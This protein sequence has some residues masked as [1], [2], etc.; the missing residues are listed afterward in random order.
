MFK[1]EDG[2]LKIRKV[3]LP[4]IKTNVMSDLQQSYRTYI[5]KTIFDDMEYIRDELRTY[6]GMET[7]DLKVRLGSLVSY[8]YNKSQTYQGKFYYPVIGTFSLKGHEVGRDM[9]LLRI[10]FMDDY[11]KINVDGASRVV[12]MVQRAAEDISYDMK[13]GLFNIA[14]PYANVRIVANHNSVKM[15]YG[16]NSYNITD[17]ITYM[18]YEA[19][20]NTKLYDVFRNTYLINAF[21]LN[22]HAINKYVHD[23]FF[24]QNP[25]ISKFRSVQYKL[26]NT[27]EALNN[28]LSIDRAA[29]CVL[30]R[31]VLDYPEGTTV[32]QSMIVE[33]KRARIN[34]IYVQARELL[35][36][37]RLTQS[38]WFNEIPAGTQNC[39]LLRRKLPQFAD[40]T[41]IPEDVT[42][43][44]QNMIVLDENSPL[45][46]EEAE[47]LLTIGYKSVLV[48]PGK[49]QSVLT[50][51]FEREIVGNYT[52]RLGELTDDIPEGRSADEWVYYYNNPTLAPIENDYLTAHDLIA[53]T[54]VMGEIH[55]TGRTQLLNRDNSF[56]KKVM[57]INEVFSES[58]RRAGKT[59]VKRYHSNI[60]AGIQSTVS[61]KAFYGLT[62]DWI[63][64]MNKERFLAPA[65]TV[66]VS[67]EVSQVNHVVTLTESS[68]EILD[69]QRHLAMPFFGRICPYETPAGKKLGIVNTKAL[70]AIVKNGLICTPYRKIIKT[71]NGI[72]ISKN[73]VYL[74][75]KDELGHKFGDAMAFKYDDN[76]NILNTYILARIPNPDIS[77]EPFIFSTIKA[78]DLADGYVPAY[79]EQFLSP[80]AA[81]IPFAGSDDP[82]RISFGLSQI[83][84]AIYLANSQRLRVRTPM[85]KDILSYSD[86][87]RFISPCDGIVK[88]VNNMHV[89]IQRFDGSMQ[90]VLM[91]GSG[92]FGNTDVTV[93]VMVSEGQKVK[94]GDLLAEAYKY[95]QAFVVRAPYSGTVI[96]IS[97]NSIEIAK[98]QPDSVVIDLSKVDRVQINNGRIMGQS[99]IFLNIKVSVGDHVEKGQILADTCMSRDGYYSPA[100]SPLVGYISIGYNY[101]DGVCASERAAVDYTSIIA[102]TIDKKVSKKHYKSPKTNTLQGFK[103][104]AKG[105]SVGKVTLKQDSNDTTKYEVAVRATEKANGI[106]Y[107]VRTIEDTPNAR[108]YRYHLLGFNKLQVGDKMAGM[109]GDKG[110][111]SKV[112]KNSM[113]PQLRNGKVMDFIIS[114]CG[115]PSRMNLGK[116]WHTH[117]GLVAEVLQVDIDTA[118]FNGATADDVA[119]MLLYAWTLANNKSIGDN[120]TKEYNKDIFNSVTSQFSKLPK[121][122]HEEVW[123]HIENVIDWRGAF[124]PDGTGDVYDPETNT[125]YENAITFG[126]PTYLKLMQ[127]AD[128]KINARAG[129]MEE[130]YARTTSQPQKSDTSAKGQR[131]AEM[132]LMALVAV[133]ASK[134]IEEILNEK[135]DNIGKNINNHIKQ[136]GLNY[137]LPDYCCK[138]RAVEN[139]LY[140]CEAMGV[141]MEV[142]KEV[143]DVSRT[144]SQQ[145]YKYDIKRIVQQNFSNKNY[146]ATVAHTE[147]AEDFDAISD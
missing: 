23:A 133:G 64:Y 89:D 104:C 40:C 27:R 109:H 111:V 106:P 67:A 65:D 142:P 138:P 122:F 84:Q 24:S 86:S 29:G 32:T 14:M 80:T 43:D 119:Y 49:S 30:S 92:H 118:S 70:G 31:P 81:L 97:D 136:L 50:Y 83:R 25:W 90:T 132:E 10:P 51:S 63:S 105:D 19:G 78:Y 46:K 143:A 17:V 18:L 99:A 71:A 129:I 103:Y 56:L 141:K 98:Y 73:V 60:L 5:T 41:T 55:V 116:M 2:V 48:H 94:T 74:S 13:K 20:D 42:L 3:D 45:D 39:A 38:L 16:K 8:T 7:L 121:E 54:S 145:K 128:E 130:Q 110:V 79:S 88:D 127:E 126:Y 9:E 53:I 21:K 108:T 96:G 114:P 76:G 66:N 134:F 36:G 113:A 28:V 72:R 135:S 144:A 22:A 4:D 77:D 26:G 107:E 61:G 58:L 93:D 15:K 57:M 117:L 69:E 59:F 146:N 6:Q 140:M 85:Y 101:E 62:G 102:H 12:L 37:Y 137:S 147:M 100:R 11:G 131:M 1:Y 44:K 35:T 123:K 47:F 95:P 139:L 124:N 115:I 82:V 68:A 87:E 34:C 75:V 125:F 120:I 112:L 52:A 33:F 91:Q